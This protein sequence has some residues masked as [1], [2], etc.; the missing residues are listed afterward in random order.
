MKLI[1]IL[2]FAR[3]ILEK[4]V[5][6]GD[7]VVD[8]TLGNGHDTV[9]LAKLVGPNGH[10][11]GFDIQ[12]AAILNSKER[13]EEQ[14]LFDQVTLCHDGHENLKEYIPSFHHGKVTGAIF[15]LGYLPGGDKSIVTKAQTTIS[16]IEQLLSIMAVEG[17][18]VLVIYHGHPEGEVE[19]DLLIDYVQTLDQKKAHVLQYGFINQT[20]HPPF[21]IAIEKRN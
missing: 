4:A 12:E 10:V 1:P 5:T 6:P 19:R 8:A 11:Y 17:I 3:S 9:F 13:L 7:S 2:P 15:N 18:I 20:N 21:I 14:K 16:A